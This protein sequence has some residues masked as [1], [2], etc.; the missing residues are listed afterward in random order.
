M[1]SPELDATQRAAQEQFSRQSE[2]YAKGH[3]L[4]AVEDVAEIISFVSIPAGARVLDVA[5][6]AGHT[7]LYLASLGHHVTCTDLSSAML[8]RTRAAASRDLLVET[9]QHPAERMPYADRSFDLV[10]CR[11]APHHFSS[12]AA[13]VSEVARVLR[14]G[15]WFVLIDGTV[16]ED[17]EETGTWLN[18]VEKLRDPTHVRLHSPREWI[19]LCHGAGLH[20]ERH[21]LRGKKQPDLEWYFETAATSPENRRAVVTLIE[22]ASAQVQKTYALDR[23]EGR[24]IW[25]W[26]MLWLIARSEAS[27]DRN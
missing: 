14:P 2:R 24:I 8:E 7:G 20:V 21:W 12:P 15:G 1:A 19:A 13:F 17:D 6:G 3:I 18:E 22:T 5:C 25:W 23:E 11:V 26:P 10:T 4:E 27:E 16:P 9:A